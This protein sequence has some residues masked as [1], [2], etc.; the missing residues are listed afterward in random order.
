[1]KNFNGHL[2]RLFILAEHLQGGK[3]YLDYIFLSEIWTLEEPPEAVGSNN[4][5]HTCFPFV[6]SELPSLFHEFEQLPHG[7]IVYRPDRSLEVDLALMEFMGLSPYEFYYCFIPGHQN[8]LS[9]DNG[10]SIHATPEEVGQHLIRFIQD[11]LDN[12]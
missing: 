12:K 5:C 2:L 6:F 9:G 11:K 3:L 8:E 7:I 10:L 4:I 1:M